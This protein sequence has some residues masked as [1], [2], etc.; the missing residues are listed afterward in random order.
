MV[1]NKCPPISALTIFFLSEA[2]NIRKNK[3]CNRL[4]GFLVLVKVKHYYVQ[5]IDCSVS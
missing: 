3:Y 5:S 4:G 2:I 1:F